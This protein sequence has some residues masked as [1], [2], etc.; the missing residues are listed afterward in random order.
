[1]EKEIAALEDAFIRQGAREAQ[2]ITGI[3][4]M[5]SRNAALR[6]EFLERL[7]GLVNDVGA[8]ATDNGTL[9]DQIDRARRNIPGARP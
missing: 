9:A 5:L 8:E 6:R 1:M 4:K 3:L 2:L 7:S